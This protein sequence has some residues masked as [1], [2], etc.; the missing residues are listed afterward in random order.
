M[1]FRETEI[2]TTHSTLTGIES[3]GLIVFCIDTEAELPGHDSSVVT[4]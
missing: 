3:D 4:E 2:R 1:S